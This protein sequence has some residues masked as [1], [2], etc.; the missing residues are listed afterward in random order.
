[1][2]GGAHPARAASAQHLWAGESAG[3]AARCRIETNFLAGQGGY[4]KGMQHPPR[5]ALVVA[6]RGTYLSLMFLFKFQSPAFL[7]PWSAVE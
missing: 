5:E 3:L 1:M 7:C 4:L 6:E 2:D